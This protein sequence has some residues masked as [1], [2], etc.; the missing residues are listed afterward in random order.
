VLL[1]VLAW[2]YLATSTVQGA[3]DDLIAVTGLLYAGFYVLTALAAIVYY[4]RRILASPLDALTIGI[5]PLA[6]AGFLGWLLARSVQAAPAPQLWSLGAIVAAGVVV[7]L[8]ARFGLRSAFF[9]IPR[10]SDTARH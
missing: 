1:L 2:L 8:V 3:F 6:A 5:L 7:M 4:R 10:E 9:T